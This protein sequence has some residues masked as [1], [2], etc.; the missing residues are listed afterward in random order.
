MDDITLVSQFREEVPEPD[1][2]TLHRIRNTV[3]A[4]L[5]DR[6]SVRPVRTGPRLRLLD[7]FRRRR[8]A[9]RFG[10]VAAA[11]AA[12]VAGTV[13]VDAVTTAD[14][15]PVVGH[16]A[17][18]A[19][20][21][22]AAAAAIRASDPPLRPGQFYYLRAVEMAGSDISDCGL[23]YLQKNVYE[24]WV[25]K[26]WEDEWML[27]LGWEVER[28][29]FRPSDEAKAKQCPLLK[30]PLAAT[31]VVKAPA[32]IFDPEGS[33]L[34]ADKFRDATGV[35]V[36]HPTP[37][38][39]A[40]RLAAGNWQG[41][42]AQFMAGL[43]RDPKQLLERI[44]RDSKG[45]GNGRD[46]EAFVFVRDILRSGVVPADLRAALFSAAALIPGVRLVSDSVNLEG[47][48]GVAVAMSDRGKTRVELIFDPKTGEVIGEREVVLVANHIKG[49]PAGAA[50]GYTAVSRQVV[51][52]MGA[53]A[54]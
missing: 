46:E 48:H 21:N 7:A 17:A 5:P 25:P 4:A 36:Y 50:I 22:R 3:V 53:T 29:F 43:P 14:G 33:K 28:Q 12:V 45:H 11:V 27:R 42:T 18:A 19:E 49:V 15:R 30:P 24:T 51:D 16:A 40:R 2:A 54:K 38:E 32:G 1:A 9:V 39:I 52:A 8:P 44:Y 35:I 47:R 37:E 31:D 23:F 20:L 13:V 6:T 34:S 10:L 41:P 26:A